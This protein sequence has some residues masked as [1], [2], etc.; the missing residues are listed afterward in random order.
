MEGSGEGSW[1]VLEESGVEARG[2]KWRPVE[3]RRGEALRMFWG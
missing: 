3:V 2:G 1:R